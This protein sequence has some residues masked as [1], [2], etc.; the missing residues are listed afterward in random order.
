MRSTGWAAGALA[1]VLLLTGCTAQQPAPAR[2]PE[3]ATAG[4]PS[5]ATPSPRLTGPPLTVAALGDSLS[6]GFD[7]CA[8]YGDCTEVSWSTGTDPRVDSVADRLS[9]LRQAPVTRVN[10]ARSGAESDDRARQGE[11]AVPRDPDLVTLLI[12]ANDVCRASTD[13][14]T[15]TTLYADRVVSALDRLSTALPSA[16]LLVASVPDVTALLPAAKDDPTARFIW[17]RLGGCA[18]V[19]DDPRSTGITAELR[20]QAVRS[21]IEEYDTALRLACA[22]HPRCVYDDG[23]L[24]GYEPELAQ[25]SALD[26]FHPSVAG[27]TEVAALQWEALEASGLTSTG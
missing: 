18:T 15:P 4:A 17:S 22:Q 24:H 14:M 1:A 26:Y 25:L 12:G 13:Q 6:R 23:A 19:L 2:T 3:R 7:A 8:R 11:A 10:V 27:L 21:R 9:R 16:T 20:R 5:P